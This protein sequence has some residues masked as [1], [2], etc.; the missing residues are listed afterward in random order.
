MVN[1]ALL[2]GWLMLLAMIGTSIS[3]VGW[4]AT[5]QAATQLTA[6]VDKNPAMYGE[7]VTLQLQLDERVDAS[8]LD[9]SALSTDFRVTGPSVSQSM[10]IVNGQASQST[11]WTFSLFAKRT[12]ELVIPSFQVAG[13][14]SAEIKLTVV[15][16]SNNDASGAELFLQ[17][18]FSVEQAFV[19]QLLYYDVKIFFKGELQS[20]SLTQ[21]EIAGAEV[22]QLGKDK[23][24]SEIVNGERY[25]TITRRYTVIPQKSGTLTLTAPAFSG[26]VIDRSVNRYD[27]FARTKKVGAQGEALTLTVQPIPADQQPWLP[28]ELVTLTEEWSSPPDQLVQGEPVTRTVT[29][30]AVDLADHQLPDLQFGA[31]DG[32][33]I[34]PEQPQSR[35]VERNGRLVAQKVFRLALIA[36]KAGTLTQPA[37]RVRWWN[38]AS[39]APAEASLPETVLQV[40]PGAQT[41]QPTVSLPGQQVSSVMADSTGWFAPRWQ[42]NYLA[43]S[44]LLL[45]L[46]TLGL[47]G[48][49]RLRRHIPNRQDPAQ[50]TGSVRFNPRK[51]AQACEQ[52]NPE[53][54]R[55]QLLRWASQVIAAD[56]QTLSQLQQQ[57]ADGTLKQQVQQL[58]YQGYQPTGATWQ[59]ADLYKAWSAYQHPTPKPEAALQPLYPAD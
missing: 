49:L 24:G 4:S 31:S 43:I 14:Q 37:V 50:T 52:N 8:T 7:A 16:A 32:V 57:L 25:Q 11:S 28:A 42:L 26:D 40:A 44:L 59:G 30:T 27:Y 29:L 2:P 1:R 6:S 36:D 34:Y 35:K 51:L 58:S 3:A 9:V 38:T 20:G 45:W 5:V 13:Q 39:H 53:L 41:E 10:Q 21:P 23:D 22:A 54:A 17:N 19:Q 47:W 46:G 18:S 15:P 48:W 56:I 12:G 55:T 33:K